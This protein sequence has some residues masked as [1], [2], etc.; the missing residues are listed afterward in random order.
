MTVS[1]IFVLDTMKKRFREALNV[2]KKEHKKIAKEME[3]KI[4]FQLIEKTF[5]TSQLDV[6][7]RLIK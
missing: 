5:L 7:R 3:S 6:I 1:G 2:G 4:R